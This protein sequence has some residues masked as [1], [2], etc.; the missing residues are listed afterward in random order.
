MRGSD[1]YNSAGFLALI[2]IGIMLVVTGLVL[3]SGAARMN[4]TA[5]V[6]FRPNAPAQA[7][8][9]SLQESARF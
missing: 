5:Q 8:P 2:L 6:A 4:E 3:M 9:V 1:D 7:S